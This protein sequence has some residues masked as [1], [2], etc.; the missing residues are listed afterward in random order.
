MLYEK[1]QSICKDRGT[2]FAQ[3][4]KALGF[5]NGTM[6]KW[7]KAS[8][9]ID[10]VKSVADYLGVSIDFLLDRSKTS[11]QGQKLADAFDELP[12]QKRDLVQRYVEMLKNE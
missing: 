8:P 5:G 9:R 2:N 12:P 11:P 3:I 1:I 7:D 6:Q 4:E 10:K